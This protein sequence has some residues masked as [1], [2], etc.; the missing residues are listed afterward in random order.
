MTTAVATTFT[1]IADSL[2]AAGV[3]ITD[4]ELEALLERADATKPR[5]RQSLAAYLTEQ[6]TPWITPNPR[7]PY[8]FARV[9]YLLQQSGHPVAPVPCAQCGR[10]TPKLDRVIDGARCCGWCA[11]RR[12]PAHL[13][14]VRAIGL[15][16]RHHRDRRYLQ[17]LLSERPDKAR[18]MQWM[19][20]S[21]RP[22]DTH[23]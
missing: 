14:P 17:P 11:S 10:I 21:S 1:V 20:T 2:T 4:G 9:T 3:T 6:D 18:N 15:P 12:K 8:V 5:S 22:L 13:R 23:C 16:S 7:C 19:R